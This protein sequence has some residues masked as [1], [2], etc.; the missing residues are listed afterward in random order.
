[1][2]NPTS[3]ALVE[4]PDGD[5]LNIHLAQPAD[6]AAIVTIEEDARDRSRGLG[7][8][9]GKPPCPLVEIVTA[10]VGRGAIAVA[11][12]AGTSVATVALGWQPE[13]LWD[14]LPGDA[15]YVHGLMVRTPF[16][17]KA[18]GQALLRWAEQRGAAAGKPLLRLDCMASNHALRAYYKRLGFTYR[19][20]A[21]ERDYV[22]SR[23]ERPIGATTPQ[24]VE[25]RDA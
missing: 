14:D 12:L 9:P 11:T 24:G 19:G 7:F 3:S 22:G 6:I 18:I 15:V 2:S 5:L 23:F 8:D 1:M 21:T 4:L 16:T 13:S 25:P 17:G 10:R 20:D